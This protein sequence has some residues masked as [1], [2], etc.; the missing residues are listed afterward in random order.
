MGYPK[1]VSLNWDGLG[2]V[3]GN[4]GGLERAVPYRWVVV[5]VVAEE[6]GLASGVRLAKKVA[7]YHCPYFVAFGATFQSRAGS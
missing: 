1:R 2:V 6:A 5:V 7:L 4:S 3:A